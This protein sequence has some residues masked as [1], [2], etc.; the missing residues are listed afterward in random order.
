MKK[1]LLILSLMITFLFTII[2]GCGKGGS[3][4]EV[5]KE[6]KSFNPQPY[7][8]YPTY[9]APQIPPPQPSPPSPY[10]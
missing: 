3:D 2:I 9:P 5:Y 1:I 6:S 7:R 8:P 4:L 10:L